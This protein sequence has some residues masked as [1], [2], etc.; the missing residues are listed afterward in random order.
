MGW[1][2]K[3]IHGR[4]LCIC[5]AGCLVLEIAYA[6]GVFVVAYLLKIEIPPV[7]GETTQIFTFSFPIILFGAAFIEEVIFRL[8]LAI[9]I[10]MRGS[11]VGVLAI[12]LLLSAIFGFLHG[13]IHHIFI[14]GVV[15]FISCIL[16]LKCG[17]LQRNYFKALAATT[18]TH[19]LFNAILVGIAIIGGATSV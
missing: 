15:G 13:G 19:F 4:Q 10:E 16:F 14:Q 5:V 6:F 1:L 3:E 8:P 17:G 11:I 12:A 7:G 18:V 9:I 2:N